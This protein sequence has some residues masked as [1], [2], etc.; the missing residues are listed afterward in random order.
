MPIIVL[1]IASVLFSFGGAN[2]PILA[3]ITLPA[4]TMSSMNW[5]SGTQFLRDF[6]R[7]SFAVFRKS[8]A[9]AMIV[10]IYNSWHL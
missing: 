3:A 4:N 1:I 5:N 8:S 2:P 7:A 10:P 9:H 6:K